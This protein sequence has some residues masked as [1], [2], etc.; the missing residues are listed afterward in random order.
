MEGEKREVRREQPQAVSVATQNPASQPATSHSPLPTSR[1]S[2][3]AGSISLKEVA[4]VK[5][6]MP[7]IKS[8]IKELTQEDL[9]RYWQQT[10]EELG[11]TEV[12][13]NGVVQLEEHPGRFVVEALTTWFHEDFKPHKMAVLEKLREK[14]GMKMLDC[15]VNP[16][17]VEKEDIV[18]SPDDKYA[19]MLQNNPQ[20]KDLR[21]LFPNID[22]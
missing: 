12:M 20:M 18:Y 4:G 21:R 15:K 16:K 6:E 19:A 1:G 17:F 11:L 8:D 5:V 22:Y 14:T 7:V 2:L 9:E 10:A 13:K 3:L